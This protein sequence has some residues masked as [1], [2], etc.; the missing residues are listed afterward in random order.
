MAEPVESRHVSSN[1]EIV[2]TLTI[3]HN[4][5]TPVI[6]GQ[7]NSDTI[8]AHG[9][10]VPAGR[11]VIFIDRWVWHRYG[12]ILL[13]IFQVAYSTVKIVK[14]SPGEPSKSWNSL[15]RLL[16]T[17]TDLHIDRRSDALYAIGGGVILDVV[18]LAASIYKRGV[19][20]AKI[21]TTLMGQIDA[22]L[23][24]KNAINYDGVKNSVGSF[25]APH[26][27]FVDFAFLQS[28]PFRHVANGVSEIIK[29]GLVLD[30]GIIADLVVLSPEDLARPESQFL[31]VIKKSICGM[32]DE[33]SRNPYEMILQRSLDFGHW[34]SPQL[35][36]LDPDLLHGEA[37]SI[38]MALSLTVSLQRGMLHCRDWHAALGLLNAW[39]LPLT[40][41][42]V[43][44]TL[45]N[46]SLERT[47][48][49]RGGSQNIPLCSGIGKYEIANDVCIEEVLRAQNLI[50]ESF[51]HRNLV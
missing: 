36:L 45:V 21:P 2:S 15:G 26:S 24:L 48:R 29:F 34:L 33:L 46:A 4:H 18:G 30:P 8:V 7:I 10:G 25:A 50:Q 47:I 3:G 51:Y 27:V 28:L 44:E 41:E 37:V 22:G 11:A 31:I 19:A 6:L 32:V 9:P 17:M 23:G 12:D 42:Q 14:V 20:L 1:A 35:E 13:S 16:S 40:H 49:H 5:R 39:G 38:D 43:N